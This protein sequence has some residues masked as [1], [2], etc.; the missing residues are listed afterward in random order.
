ML[1]KDS[2]WCP[3]VRMQCIYMGLQLV[4]GHQLQFYV[5]FWVICVVW[6]LMT[7]LHVEMAI[8][9]LHNICQYSLSFCLWYKNDQNLTFCCWWKYRLFTI[10]TNKLLHHQFSKNLASATV[11]WRIVSHG[12]S[13]RYQ[14]HKRLQFM[15][16]SD[17]YELPWWTIA[18]NSFVH[19]L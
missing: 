12:K 17:R 8:V 1:D 3:S 7:M 13:F 16:L 18:L 19:Y 6:S 15:V 11:D 14:L 2:D 10:S 4:D 9:T 5:V